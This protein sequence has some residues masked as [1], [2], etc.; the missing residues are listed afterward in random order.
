[1]ATRSDLGKFATCGSL[2][3]EEDF[4]C[5][6]DSCA[7]LYMLDLVAELLLLFFNDSWLNLGVIIDDV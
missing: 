1:M 3:K 7:F 4:E 6:P 5:V 2:E